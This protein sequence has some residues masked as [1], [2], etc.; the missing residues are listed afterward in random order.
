MKPQLTTI[1]LALIAGY[2]GG[3]SSQLFHSGSTPPVGQIH[4]EQGAEHPSSSI[5]H[6]ETGELTLQIVQ[7][8]QKADRLEL[9]LDELTHNR[10]NI[11]NNTDNITIKKAENKNRQ[12]RPV[13]L[14]KDNLVSAGVDPIIADD[15]LRRI[16]QQEFRRLELQNLIQRST[17]SERQQYNAE[18]RELNE[19]KISLRSELGDDAYDQYLVVSGQNNRMKVTSVMAGSPAELNG[20]Q[21]DDVILYYDDKIIFDLPEL[22]KAT[23]EGEIGNFTNVVILRDGMR[24]S[25]FV[26][27]GTLGVQ[28]EAIKFDPAQHQ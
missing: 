3:I 6:T 1:V 14:N 13:T 17:S 27:R 12:R 24:M 5:V 11:E 28:L 19:N 15:I 21:K 2:L 7:L 26:P 25:I 8:Q 22:R 9:Q 10:V 16:S 4:T 20:M 23:L 18:L